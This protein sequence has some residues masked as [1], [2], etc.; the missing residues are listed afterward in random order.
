L[1]R[2]IGSESKAA[3]HLEVRLDFGERSARDRDESPEI[4]PAPAL[5]SFGQ[6]CRDRNRGPLEL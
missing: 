4:A 3:H 1:G 5:V 6:I 2:L